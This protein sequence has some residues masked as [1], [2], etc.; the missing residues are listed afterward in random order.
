M[1]IKVIVV[2][3]FKREE[4]VFEKIDLAIVAIADLQDI[5]FSSNFV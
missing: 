5:C 1:K 2:C 3:D 4:I